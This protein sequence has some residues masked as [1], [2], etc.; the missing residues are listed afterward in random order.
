MPKDD[1]IEFEGTVLE[2][3]PNAN[4]KVKLPNILPGVLSGM[5]MAFTLSLDDFVISY[6][7]AGSTAQTLS[8]TIY[9]MTKKPM[10]PEINAL[11]TLMFGTVLLLL[12]VVNIR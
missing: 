12:L 4:F 5:V 3:L 7:N 1:V 6:F 2:A 8:V 9:S 11:S 10:T